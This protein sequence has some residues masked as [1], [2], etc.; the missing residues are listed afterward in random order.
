MKNKKPVFGQIL[1][2]SL[3]KSYDS[4][5]SSKVI[6][7]KAFLGPQSTTS[8]KQEESP[9]AHLAHEY[10]RNYWKWRT[11][12][13]DTQKGELLAEFLGVTDQEVMDD[14]DNGKS[15]DQILKENQTEKS[16]YKN[17]VFNKF[18]NRIQSRVQ[19]GE[20]DNNFANNL[21]SNLHIRHI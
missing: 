14:L 5:Q 6:I 16:N 9:E 7:S 3:N 4:L 20:I 10:T 15:I 17:F 18:V 1:K 11:Q 12:S 8:Q 19:K 13:K 21:V 2:T